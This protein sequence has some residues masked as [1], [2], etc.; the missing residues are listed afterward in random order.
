[1]QL[2][3]ALMA[4]QVAARKSLNTWRMPRKQD[5]E[6]QALAMSTILCYM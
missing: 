1:M 4:I 6:M 3:A 2:N 5:L